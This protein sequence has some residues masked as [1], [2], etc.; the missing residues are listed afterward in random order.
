MVSGFGF[1]VAVAHVVV[2]FATS[3]CWPRTA[4]P[5]KTTLNTNI[6]AVIIRIGFWGPLYYSYITPHLPAPYR[7]S[8]PKKPKPENTTP[9]TQQKPP[10]TLGDPNP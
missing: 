8:R 6:E 4:D 3:G 5:P 9:K 10:Y 7:S 1:L 2:F